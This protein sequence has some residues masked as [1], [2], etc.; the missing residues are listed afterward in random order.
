M[1]R[2]VIRTPTRK[3]CLEFLVIHGFNLHGLI[4][5]W[6]LNIYGT[7]PANDLGG[8]FGCLHRRTIK[9]IYKYIVVMAH[10]FCFG[11]DMVVSLFTTSFVNYTSS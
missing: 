8:F 9:N 2:L 7:M 10:K 6:I 3:P 11:F 4:W 5:G 1:K